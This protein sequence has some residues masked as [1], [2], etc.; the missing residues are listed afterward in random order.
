MWVGSYNGLHKHEGSRIKTYKRTG[1]DSAAISSSEMHG[2]FEDRLG[3]IWIGTTAGLD[4]LDPVTGRIKHYS[5]HSSDSKSASVGYIYSVFQDKEDYIWASTDA[6]LYRIN[7]KTG[8]HTAI[9]ISRSSNGVPE[10]VTGYK[11][12]I[13]T[14]KGLW[15]HTS[16]GMMY[17]EYSSRKFFHRYHNPEN[18]AIFNLG[19]QIGFVG[20]N[21]DLTT[22]AKN[23]LYFITNNSHLARYNFTTEKLDTFLFEQP[24]KAWYCCYSLSSDRYNNIWIGFRHGGI[25]VF[26]P[27]TQIFKPIIYENNNSL[28]SSNYI[29][30]LC[31]DYTGR[32]WITGD[33]GI[34]VVDLYNTAIQKNTLSPNPDFTNLV[35]ESGNMTADTSGKLYIPFYGGGLMKVNTDIFKVK[36]LQLTDTSIKRVSYIFKDEKAGFIAGANKT[37]YSLNLTNDKLSLKELNT[38]YAKALNKIRGSVIWM[39]KENDQSFYFKKTDGNIYH[40]SGIDSMERIRSSGFTR[41]AFVSADRKYLYYI[42]PDLNLAKRSLDTRITD[43]INLQEKLRAQEISFATPREITEDGRGNIWLT[44]QNGLLRYNLASQKIVSYTQETGLSHNFTFTVCSDSRGR[45][46]AGSLGGVDWYNA[47]TDRFENVVGYSSGTYMDAFGSSL[48]MKNDILFFHAGNNLFRINAEEFLNQPGPSHLLK[49]NDVSVNGVVVNTQ[50]NYLENLS[51]RQNRIQINFSL[52]DFGI[53][54]GVKF[55]YY[56]EGAE[57]DWIEST[58]PEVSY[59]SLPPGRYV[60]HAKATEASGKL[61]LEQILLP[62]RIIAPFW[63]TWWFRLLVLTIIGLL[64]YRIFKSR[65]NAVKA[66]AAVKLQIAELEGKAL[67]AQ[68]NPHFIF[69]SLNAIQELIV[70]KKITEGYTYLASFSK[71]LRM[72]LH[73]SEKNFIPLSAEIEMN[74]HYLQLESLRFKQS[75]QYEMHVDDEIDQETTLVPSL[76]LQPYLENAIWHGLLQ[77]EGDKNLEVNFKDT[78]GFIICTIEDNGIGRERSAA[79]KA[80]KL[81]GAY[82]ESKGMELSSQRIAALNRQ[83]NKNF[84]LN[85]TDLKD[86]DGYA[87]GTRVTITIPKQ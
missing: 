49:V 86:E 77:K 11:S 40:Y 43:T 44:S 66:K 85:I 75:F 60:F 27:K 64:I 55:Y 83:L 21:S 28:I 80:G 57:K 41:L 51:Y 2:L 87:A 68:M 25:L 72:V 74:R 31:E 18:K 82:S 22:D 8:N 71:L 37:L 79:V 45:V 62:I 17:Y 46:W 23:N 7:Y 56:L 24:A 63:Q 32:M 10:A 29:Y 84:T 14:H 73:N 65:V 52:L 69:N 39:H 15:M 47:A 4:K 20:S 36:H 30:S 16:A 54:H 76:L 61:I 12:G 67:R 42:T 53:L 58:R 48:V 1:K 35:Y 19:R 50:N 33:K 70:T 9:P 38:T 81:R 5:L 6:G 26:N 78:D 34:D 13:S 3:Y 59:N